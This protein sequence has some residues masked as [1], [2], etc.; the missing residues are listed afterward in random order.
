LVG[1]TMHDLHVLKEDTGKGSVALRVHW[2]ECTD[3]CFASS[4]KSVQFREGR[5]EIYIPAR[6]PLFCID[7]FRGGTVV[8]C[9]GG[10]IVA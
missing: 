10:Q 2:T 7:I 3:H 6:K 5:V 4:L 1:E 8:G 9:Y